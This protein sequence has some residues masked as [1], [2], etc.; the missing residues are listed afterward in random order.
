MENKT[1]SKQRAPIN[2]C[3]RGILKTTTNDDKY[4]DEVQQV[5]KETSIAIIT[6]LLG[7]IPFNG[8][9][10]VSKFS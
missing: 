7:N 2:T 5:I 4:C 1:K 8:C 6:C 3:I 9:K 10:L